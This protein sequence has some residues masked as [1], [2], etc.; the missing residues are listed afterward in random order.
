MSRKNAYKHLFF[1]LRIPVELCT[2]IIYCFFVVMNTFKNLTIEKIPMNID[3]NNMFG[4]CW[5]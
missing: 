2:K 3:Q 1:I 5:S 4:V